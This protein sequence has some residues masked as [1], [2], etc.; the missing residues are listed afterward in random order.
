MNASCHGGLDQWTN[1]LVLDGSLVLSES[2]FLISVDLGNVLKIALTTLVANWAIE[3]VIGKEELHYT[4]KDFD[5]G[6]KRCIEF[7]YPLAILVLSDLVKILR[8]G[9]T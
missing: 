7:T 9:L 4:T 5:I 3:R 6:L 1:V 8:S 2:T